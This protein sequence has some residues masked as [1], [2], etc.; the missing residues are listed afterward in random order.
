VDYAQY[1]VHEKD[2]LITNAFTLMGGGGFPLP[3]LPVA[4]YWRVVY[5]GPWYNS[6]GA[7]PSST[8]IIQQSAITLQS[9]Q[10]DLD[11]Y[12]VDST[13]PPVAEDSKTFTAYRTVTSSSTTMAEIT[14]TTIL[15]YLNTNENISGHYPDVGKHTVTNIAILKF[16]YG[17]PITIN[18]FMYTHTSYSRA[19]LNINPTTVRIEYS[20]DDVNWTLDHEY[21]KDVDLIG[22]VTHGTSG[23]ASSYAA[24]AM[25]FQRNMTTGGWSPSV[26]KTQLKQ[27]SGVVSTTDF[28]NTFDAFAPSTD[29]PSTVPVSDGVPDYHVYVIAGDVV[30]VGGVDNYDT[31]GMDQQVGGNDGEGAISVLDVDWGTISAF[32]EIPK[33]ALTTTPGTGLY[34]RSCAL[35]A[36]GK[37]ALVCGYKDDSGDAYI[38]TYNESSGD[39]DHTSGDTLSISSGAGGSYGR[40]CAMSADGKTVLIAGYIGSFNGGCAYI[41]NYTESGGWTNTSGTTMNKAAATTIGRYGNSCALSLDGKTALVAGDGTVSSGCAFI[42]NLVDGEW[43]EYV[44]PVDVGGDGLNITTGA[45]GN[46]G[47]S[48]ALSGDGKT[49]IVAGYS[50]FSAGCAYIWNY[51]QT[52]KQW[53]KYTDGGD[54]LNKLSGAPGRYG[55]TCDM[56]VDGKTVI[57]SGF[58]SSGTSGCAYIWEY[59]E[60]LEIWEETSGTELNKTSASGRYG[61]S[62]SLSADGKTVLISGYGNTG[63][64]AYVWTYNTA[65]GVWEQTSGTTMNNSGSIVGTYGYSC[66]LSLDG[67]TA[68]VGTGSTAVFWQGVD[69]GERVLM[70]YKSNVDTSSLSTLRTTITAASIT[71]GNIIVSGEVIADADN[72]TT[73]YMM[74]ATDA[75]LTNEQVR[76]MILSGS[77]GTALMSAVVSSGTTE[78]LTGVVVPNVVDSSNKVVPAYT[79]NNAYVYMYASSSGI[80]GDDIDMMAIDRTVNT[81]YAT[82]SDTT[83]IVDVDGTKTLQVNGSVFSSVANCTYYVFSFVTM[84]GDA[85]PLDVVTEANLT[86]A[87][88]ITFVNGYLTGTNTLPYDNNVAYK[89]DTGAAQRYALEEL[90]DVP[91]TKAFIKLQPTEGISNYV[92]ITDALGWEF[93]TFIFAVDTG[94]RTGVGKIIPPV[95]SSGAR[96]DPQPETADGSSTLFGATPGYYMELGN[97]DKV[98]SS[99]TFATNA[100][101]VDNLFHYDPVGGLD[102]AWLSNGVTSWETDVQAVYEFAN[103][104]WKTIYK[105]RF[106]Q[107]PNT[108]NMAGVI[109]IYYSSDGGT[110]FTEVTYLAGSPPEFSTNVA[111]VWIS[112]EF[113]PVS[114]GMFKIRVNSHTE[115]NTSSGAVGLSDWDLY[116]APPPFGVD[117]SSG[118]R[119]QIGAGATLDMDAG[120]INFS[121]RAVEDSTNATTF[122]AVATTSPNLTNEQVRSLINGGVYADALT[123]ADTLKNNGPLTMNM[124][125]TSDGGVTTYRAY[126]K[127]GEQ[128]TNTF[129]TGGY[130]QELQNGING[131][132]G[133]VGV[134]HKAHSSAAGHDVRNLFNESTIANEYNIINTTAGYGSGWHGNSNPAFVAYEFDVPTHVNAMRFIQ[135]ESGHGVGTIN[136]YYWNSNTIDYDADNWVSV[137]SPSSSGFTTWTSYE[138]LEISFD[139]VS[140]IAFKVELYILLG[141]VTLITNW[142]LHLVNWTPIMSNSKVI[143]GTT[144]PYTIA[145]VSAVNYATLYMYGTDGVVVDS[146]A[147]TKVLLDEETLETEFKADILVSDENDGNN[148]LALTTSDEVHTSTSQTLQNGDIVHMTGPQQNN[149]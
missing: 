48:C 148:V 34:G 60:T 71:N 117:S 139:T 79:V 115:H 106:S 83:A 30:D 132:T 44:D 103:S 105:M 35:S 113:E 121:G 2:Y 144:P 19:D 87:N 67:R 89:S 42:W 141:P 69:E 88:L 41:W 131:V 120:V 122:Y 49:A 12:V 101:S 129:F 24:D 142:T 76:T 50:S 32:N 40:S 99:G 9:G 85:T 11:K 57:V 108:T 22:L 136:I 111:K 126:T 25:F 64:C 5:G 116:E 3:A 75:N 16:D 93:K 137:S 97:M 43:V 70:S 145:P 92:D 127:V 45:S 140:S 36:D 66:A 78:T 125:T 104:D 80:A 65:T 63:G 39:W 6:S 124:K 133:K 31:I 53:V 147:M 96:A 27:R 59:D 100:S 109:H 81:P 51:N 146:D 4:R 8:S 15:S 37:T 26:L 149:S 72:D 143:A 128:T 47:K 33:S 74:A 46:Y 21:T 17:T 58:A 38:W 55:F 10:S 23:V 62:C 28:V 14:D 29:P 130:Y 91:L 73:Y 20:E 18:E 112:S 56:S 84:R 7:V 77:Y 135:G 1:A 138:E 94:N 13:L 114:G 52:S 95:P 118:L 102:S 123:N 134:I 107:Y 61:H 86:D 119:A 90:V 98:H 68:L 82:V 54:G 110:T